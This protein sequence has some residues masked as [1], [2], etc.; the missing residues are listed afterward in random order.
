MLEQSCTYKVVT[1]ES[2]NVDLIP[3]RRCYS[4]L[5]TEGKAQGLQIMTI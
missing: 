1:C 5:E 3:M 4:N 2:V